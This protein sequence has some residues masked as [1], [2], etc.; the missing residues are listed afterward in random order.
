MPRRLASLSTFSAFSISSNC[1]KMSNVIFQNKMTIL[2]HHKDPA[3]GGGGGKREGAVLEPIFAG[4][5]P[6][7]LSE[8]LPLSL[9]FVPQIDLYFLIYT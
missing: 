6:L 9:S 7:R 2:E 3:G 5:V 1:L 8:P 4:Y